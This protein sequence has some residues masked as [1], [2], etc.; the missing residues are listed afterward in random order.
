MKTYLGNDAPL[1]GTD[2]KPHPIDI[3][4]HLGR[5]HRFGGAANPEWT[6]LHHSMLVTLIWLK[7]IGTSGVH[8]A[9]LH[10]AHEYI[11][12][13]I[14][15]PVKNLF[16]ESRGVEQHLDQAI[17]GMLGESLP[18]QYDQHF[19]KV[20]DMAALLIESFYFG[21]RACSFE[22][23]G[24]TVWQKA[25]PEFRSEVAR[26]VKAFDEAVYSSM[27]HSPTYNQERK[28]DPWGL[29]A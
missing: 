16:G 18:G 2:H 24:E 12:G 9:L 27:V 4:F 25:Q 10:D 19:I 23:M 22:H 20:V 28:Q 1:P 3:V 7:Y 26:C 13:D 15:T 6:V 5:T 21:E 11:T 17:Y 8:H 14:P 29:L